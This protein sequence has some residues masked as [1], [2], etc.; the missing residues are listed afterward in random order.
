MAVLNLYDYRRS[1]EIHIRLAVPVD[2]WVSGQVH[3][4]G[5]RSGAQCGP[6]TADRAL[7]VNVKVRSGVM[8]VHL[9]L[10]LVFYP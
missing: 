4:H 9:C 8:A 10:M 7:H 5:T 1:L 6:P 3:Q 2:T